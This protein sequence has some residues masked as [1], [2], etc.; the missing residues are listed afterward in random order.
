M[1]PFAV[2]GEYA[3]RYVERYRGEYQQLQAFG[4][5][6]RA[7]LREALVELST[8]G[9]CRLRLSGDD[10]AQ[11]E[12]PLFYVET[13]REAYRRSENTPEAPFPS[14]AGLGITIP[15]ELMT[16][17]NVTT[18]LGGLMQGA[19]AATPLVRLLFAE[20]LR[21]IVV[22]SE[23]IRSGL[24]DVALAKLKNYLGLAN[25]AAYVQSRLAPAY[26]GNKTAVSDMISSIAMRLGTARQTIEGASDA[27]FRFWAQ[28]THVIVAEKKPGENEAAESASRQAAHIIAAYAVALRTAGQS[29]QNEIRASIKAVEAQFAREPFVYSLKEIYAL[30]DANG[31][32]VL[33]K[34]SQEA[35]L[36]FLKD[37]MRPP[38]GKL[39]PELM[40]IKIDERTESFVH[41]DRLIPVFLRTIPTVAETADQAI[42]AEWERCLRSG[43]RPAAMVNDGAFGEDVSRAV[44]SGHPLF[45]RLLDETL[46]NN[47]QRETK[48]A[49]TTAL[50][51]SRCFDSR[52]QKLKPLPQILA[53]DRRAILARARA[54]VPLWVRIPFLRAIAKF[55]R[56]L[57]GGRAPSGAS[58][59]GPAGQ[60]RPAAQGGGR[61]VARE[62]QPEAPATT[63]K[64]LDSPRSGPFRGKPATLKQRTAAW[65]R[66]LERLRNRFA[67][68]D[69]SL[70]ASLDELA[71]K[72]NPLYEPKAR[73]DLREDVDSMT[74][75]FLRGILRHGGTM[76][77]PDAE[78]ISSLAQRLS[79][80]PAFDR[81]RRK[82]LFVR[83]VELMMIKVL[84]DEHGVTL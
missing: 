76:K 83:Y 32:P 61:A 40:R 78:R 70:S 63:V 22:P 23:M 53:L 69:K 6:V 66:D 37:K 58:A 5:D 73:A 3:E 26:H 25:N 24:L 64:R 82:D 28:L 56:G 35:F 10:I 46:L 81:I 60:E 31:A 7:A 47:V 65:K 49:A 51:L 75:S 8:S 41:R 34:G 57:F 36:E 1:V 29:Q 16:T 77:A 11:V 27:H 20:S 30:R 12:F 38:A 79:A 80:N 43:Q 9:Q 84:A 4:S 45:F 48:L 2:L 42:T 54:A 33:R 62:V 71:E 67:G 59:P 14:E 52:G 13:V 74:R 50:E 39:V 72:W 17:A 55:L 68:G 18:D 21:S 15:N 44:Q 19:E